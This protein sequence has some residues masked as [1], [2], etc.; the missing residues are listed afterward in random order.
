LGDFLGFTPLNGLSISINS[1]TLHLL[2]N[3]PFLYY[4]QP[5]NKFIKY[6]KNITHVLL[7][8][9]VWAQKTTDQIILALVADTL[10]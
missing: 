7:G 4:T 8:I 10:F 3:S 5:R 2:E 6:D 1:C 9:I